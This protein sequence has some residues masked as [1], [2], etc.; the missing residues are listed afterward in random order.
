MNRTLSRLILASTLIPGVHPFRSLAVE[1]DHPVVRISGSGI[2]KGVVLHSMA[3]R[4]VAPTRAKL[5][6]I[7]MKGVDGRV[8][9]EV[10]K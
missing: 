1:D 8:L 10:L 4:D 9:T 5:P 7:E 3:N 6:G 2:T